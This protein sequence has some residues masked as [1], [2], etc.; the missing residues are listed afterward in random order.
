MKRV[1]SLLSVLTLTGIII[2]FPGCSQPLIVKEQ[3]TD[4]STKP[5]LPLLD[6]QPHGPLETA[7]FALG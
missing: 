3:V 1:L 7:Y 2:M 4:L 6:S 5:A